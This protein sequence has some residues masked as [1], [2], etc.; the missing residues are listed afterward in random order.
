MDTCWQRRIR[1]VLSEHP[2]GLTLAEIAERIDSKP[3][4][5]WPAL[6]TLAQ[7]G[8]VRES[9]RRSTTARRARHI[10]VWRLRAL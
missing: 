9:W 10:T 8:L 1:R 6:D 3:V 4:A 2:N 5:V 7:A